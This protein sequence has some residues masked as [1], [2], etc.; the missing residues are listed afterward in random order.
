MVRLPEALKSEGGKFLF[1]P[2]YLDACFGTLLCT[3]PGWQDTSSKRLFLPVAFD[4]VRF[5]A[6][7]GDEVWA[8]ARLTAADPH[9]LTGDLSIMDGSGRCLMEIRGF[10]ARSVATIDSGNLLENSLYEDEWIESAP[11]PQPENLQ[12]RKILVLADQGGFGAELAGALSA[13]G[14]EVAT[15]PPGDASPDT[16]LPAALEHHS[17]ETIV[18]CRNL[19]ARHPRGETPPLPGCRDLVAWFRSLALQDDAATPVRNIVVLT[20]GARSVQPGEA[21]DPVQAASCGVV[22]TARLELPRVAGKLVDISGDDAASSLADV[23]SEIAAKDAETET[24]WRNG[25][26]HVPRLRRVKPAQL[27]GFQPPT[28]APVQV[29]LRQPGPGVELRPAP[30]RPGPGPDEVLIRVAAA[31]VNFRDTMKALGIYPVSSELD[32]ILGDECAG[33]VLEAGANV[34]HVSPGDRVI[35]VTPGCF[36]TEVTA[37]SSCV[38]RCPAN[39]TPAQASTM[40]VVFLTALYA[41]ARGGTDQ[42]GREGADPFR[43]RGV[44]LAAVQIAQLLGAECSPPQAAK[45]SAGCSRGWASGT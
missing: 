9:L 2:A 22:R 43:R 34:H 41:P 12:G 20:R 17:A 1:H 40:P 45:T 10:R 13:R 24:A 35:A 8:H 38:V 42:A 33:T 14:A 5:H 11:L 19:D 37:R 31:G 32:L 16:A 36:S 23:V 29:R 26:R 39:I 30:P 21:A 27:R 18:H 25:I 15:I 7:P 3:F 4:L 28:N 44:G 6:S